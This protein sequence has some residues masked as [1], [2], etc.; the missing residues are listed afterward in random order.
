MPSITPN[1]ASSQSTSSFSFKQIQNSDLAI[2]IFK[3]YVYVQDLAKA[4][5]AIIGVVVVGG[6]TVLIGAWLVCRGCKRDEGKRNDSGEGRTGDINDNKTK[7]KDDKDNEEEVE[8]EEGD[9][10][11]VTGGETDKVTVA[12]V[13]SEKVDLSTRRD[14]LIGQLKEA[15]QK[16]PLAT[17]KLVK[18]IKDL[19]RFWKENPPQHLK[20]TFQMQFKVVKMLEEEVEPH[21]L[22]ENFYTHLLSDVQKK[23]AQKEDIQQED[24]TH[25][26]ELLKT[27]NVHK[28]INKQ[29]QILE[30]DFRI[31]QQQALLENLNNK[32]GDDTDALAGVYK[33]CIGALESYKNAISNNLKTKNTREQVIE[34]VKKVNQQRA[35]FFSFAVKLKSSPPSNSSVMANEVKGNLSRILTED[36]FRFKP[37]PKKKEVRL[38]RLSRY[39]KRIK[40]LQGQKFSKLRD[41]K[42]KF[43]KVATYVPGM[44]EI[45]FADILDS[46]DEDDP[47]RD[48]LQA[49]I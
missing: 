6:V 32:F 20:K 49:H 1:S 42:Q 36:S 48:V 27:I 12:S 15:L 35:K 13:V 26:N 40:K 47:S 29:L 10:R 41:L 16:K 18:K 44:D 7:E 43:P 9:N 4:H 37:D 45:Q 22:G 34:S 31:A 3:N 11:A 19:K 25:L 23:Y 24:I 33:G 30:I 17:F 28:K 39:H 21:V 2:K 14:Q 46:I 38:Q 5:K 8:K